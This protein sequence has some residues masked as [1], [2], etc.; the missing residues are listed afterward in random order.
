MKGCIL[1]KQN[2]GCVFYAAGTGQGSVTG[3]CEYGCGLW[4]S[5]LVENFLA[6]CL[7]IKDSSP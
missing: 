2:E 6:H 1:K 5:K 3:T 4:V 7:I